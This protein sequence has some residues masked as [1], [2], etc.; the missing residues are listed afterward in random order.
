MISDLEDFMQSVQLPVMSIANPKLKELQERADAR[1]RKPQ[2]EQQLEIQDLYLKVEQE[3]V[4]VEN[5]E[6]QR[7]LQAQHQIQERLQHKMQVEHLQ[8]SQRHLHFQHQQQMQILQ[9]LLQ[10]QQSGQLESHQAKQEQL[11]RLQQALQAQKQ[12]QVQQKMQLQH[13]LNQPRPHILRL[14]ME[15][16]TQALIPH[17]QTHTTQQPQ[18]PP[19][20]Q[21]QSLGSQVQSEHQSQPQPGNNLESAD[22]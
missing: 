16:P 22:P 8:R 18:Q 1:E 10:Q 17:F 5:L 19:L 12:E 20:Y 7:H 9:E 15:P 2:R 6:L 11:S 21:D 14:P 13:L 4:R 3:H